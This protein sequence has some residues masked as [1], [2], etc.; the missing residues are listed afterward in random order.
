M[1]AFESQGD[2]MPAHQDGAD[3]CGM[4]IRNYA[5]ALTPVAGL[6]AVLLL[7]ACGSGSGNPSA[8]TTT[9]SAQDPAA[10]TV[11]VTDREDS[12]WAGYVVA[13]SATTKTSFSNVSGSWT[14]PEADCDAGS[15]SHSAFW[16]GIGG[17]SGKHLEQT[18]TSADCSASGQ[19]VYSVWYE[20][21]PAAEVPVHMTIQPGDRL[22]AH[23]AVS[24]H[25]V[26]LSISDL[27]KNTT[28][29]KR[30]QM[31]SPTVSSA[32]W[33]AEA[34]SRC[35]SASSQDCHILSLA[36]F[37]SVTFTGASVSAGGRTGPITSGL[38]QVSAL[39]LEANPGFG[40]LYA[41]AAQANASPGAL[42]DNG[43]SFAVN[44]QAPEIQMPIPPVIVTGPIYN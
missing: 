12:N 1:I 41:T 15:P 3:A 31:S 27:T 43:S 13:S 10:S 2:V 40:R 36:D 6:A 39:T 20:L 37:G 7:T 42:S 32:E 11:M 22:N 16:V 19:A 33:I 14:Q 9:S 24:G 17:Y 29:S 28:F 25:T 8:G 44:W 21:V 35:V 26:T 34:P 18:G 23:V 30:L 4:N 5:T 38:G